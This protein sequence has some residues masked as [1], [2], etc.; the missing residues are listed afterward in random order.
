MKV[1]ETK[2]DGIRVITPRVF[3]DDRG[4]FM[5]T[6]NARDAA[7]VGLP[8]VFVQDNH[9]F[10]R[11]GVLRGLHYQHPQWQAKLIR[12][13]SGEVFDVAVDI[14]RQSPTFGHWVGV[15]LSAD[16]RKQMYVP[17]GFAH[18]F[19]VTSQGADVL[20]KVTTLYAPEQDHCIVWNDPDINVTWPVAEPIVS[21]KDA[22][23]VRLKD[24]HVD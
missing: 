16:N 15:T 23:G 12:V 10:S 13:V 22:Q 6:F 11:Y 9:S 24:V 20:Y 14:R 4:F 1:E 2:L 3:D 7:A 17:A 19:C 21:H 8:K 5:E 18:G